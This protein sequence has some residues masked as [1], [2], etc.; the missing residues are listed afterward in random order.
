[1]LREQEKMNSLESLMGLNRQGIPADM[2]YADDPMLQLAMQGNDAAMMEGMG[3]P[4]LEN[5]YELVGMEQPQGGDIGNQ[6]TQQMLGGPAPQLS[7]PEINALA[8]SLGIGT[9]NSDPMTDPMYS[10]QYNIMSILGGR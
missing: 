4:P 1:M 7:Q 10:P 3:V 2:A 9:Q 6:L 5:P 8:Q